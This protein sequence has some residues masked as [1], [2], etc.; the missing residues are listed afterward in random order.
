MS[1][2]ND[3]D[4]DYDSDST[5][6]R[7]DAR[8]RQDERYDTPS[9]QEKVA[10]LRAKVDDLSVRWAERT[11]PAKDVSQDGISLHDKV[12]FLKARVRA[13][14]AKGASKPETKMDSSGDVHERM[15]KIKAKMAEVDKQIAQ[16]GSS[17][18]K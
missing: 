16:L 7:L 13:I 8:Y 5:H 4:S 3:D 12:E 15:F 6:M 17:D 2:M 1:C 11:S 9:A 10:F 14:E 18:W